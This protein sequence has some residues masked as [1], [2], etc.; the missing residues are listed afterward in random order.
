VHAVLP[1]VVEALAQIVAVQPNGSPAPV[2]SYLPGKVV[3]D[4]RVRLSNTVDFFASQRFVPTGLEAGM[5]NEINLEWELANIHR[6]F[7]ERNENLGR[8][9]PGMTKSLMKELLQIIDMQNRTRVEKKA[10]SEDHFGMEVEFPAEYLALRG[11]SGSVRDQSADVSRR[12]NRRKERRIKAMK[13]GQEEPTIM[14]LEMEDDVGR[15]V[16]RNQSRVGARQHS[17]TLQ[18]AQR[19]SRSHHARHD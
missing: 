12:M 1:L 8:I 15:H 16:Q 13:A 11:I 6:L 7:S 5:Y 3:N 14:T 4:T 19:E 17:S 18:R 10:T 9:M 2:P